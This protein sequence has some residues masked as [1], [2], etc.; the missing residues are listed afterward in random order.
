[1]GVISVYS[2]K[3]LSLIYACKSIKSNS[4]DNRETL[5]KVRTRRCKA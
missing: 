1:M 5:P 2:R 4:T 3:D